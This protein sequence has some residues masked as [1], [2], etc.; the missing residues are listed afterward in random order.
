[1]RSVLRIMPLLL[2]LLAAGVVRK[3]G[4]RP[5]VAMLSFAHG[6]ANAYARILTALGDGMASVEWH[7]RWPDEPAR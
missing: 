7:G 5:R 1:M 3:L 2:A 6:H 4:I